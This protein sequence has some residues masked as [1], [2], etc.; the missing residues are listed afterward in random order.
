MNEEKREGVWVG[1]AM[2]HQQGLPSSDVL[3]QH[4]DYDVD[5]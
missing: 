4:W 1:V 2:S 3:E 5:G